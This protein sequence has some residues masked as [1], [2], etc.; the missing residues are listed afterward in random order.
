MK[1]TNSSHLSSSR[2]STTTESPR[3]FNKI[4]TWFKFRFLRRHHI[5]THAVLSKTSRGAAE[6]RVRPTKARPITNKHPFHSACPVPVFPLEIMELIIYEVWNLLLG[7]KAR[8]TFRRTSMRVSH[9]WMATFM[10]IS[11]ANIHITSFAYFKYIWY[12]IRG[13]K[14]IARKYLDLQSYIGNSCRSITLYMNNDY[15]SYKYKCRY[16]F[17]EHLACRLG[18]R[19]DPNRMIHILHDVG[20]FPKFCNNLL[21]LRHVHLRYHNRFPFDPND[22]VYRFHSF[23]TTVTDLEITHTFDDDCRDFPKFIFDPVLKRYYRPYERE[24]AFFEFPWRLPYIRR[25]TV[26]G[27]NAAL[28]LTIASRAEGLEEI[29]TDVDSEQVTT[30]L[31][32]LDISNSPGK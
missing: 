31:Q 7:T 15:N 29:T 8:R 17:P 21:A 1:A 16:A 30:G 24:L 23:P 5:R 25:L 22:Y 19:G 27:G 12:L 18:P 32:R 10:R 28:V 20:L 13:G 4:L 9:A 14:S 6:M 11:L 3:R 2:I 26:R